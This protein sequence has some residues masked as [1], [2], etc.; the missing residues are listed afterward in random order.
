MP[1][2][3]IQPFTGCPRAEEC[4]RGFTVVARWMGTEPD[5][6]VDVDWSFDAV[7]ASRTRLR[8]RRTPP[9]PP[10][11]TSGSI[12][13]LHSPRLQGRAEG[14]FDLVSAGG[15]EGWPGAVG[16]DPAAAGR[17]ATSGPRRRRRA[18]AAP[19]GRQGPERAGRPRGLGHRPRNS[20]SGGLAP[21]RRRRH[22][23][24][25]D[26]PPARSAASTPEPCTGSIEIFVDSRADRDATI[27]WDV[28]VE[29]PVP[30]QATRGRTAQG[31]GGQCSVMR[32]GRWS[33]S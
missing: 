24:P 6:T 11:S 7:A 5:D 29:L 25:D 2:A 4:V 33:S 17:C 23:A 31:R 9:W 12:S 10:R 19:G 28:A 15:Q 21:A 14:S 13:G 20:S 26:R 16:R 27:S 1:A 18:G 8:S 32:G 3:F 22:R 30:S